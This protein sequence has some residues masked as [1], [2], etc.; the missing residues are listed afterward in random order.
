MKNCFGIVYYILNN[1]R[2]RLPRNIFMLPT[3][4]IHTENAKQ[5][6]YLII[7]L[8]IINWFPAIFLGKK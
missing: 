1:Y 3:E 7:A 2:K 5:I 4:T 8:E 6:F